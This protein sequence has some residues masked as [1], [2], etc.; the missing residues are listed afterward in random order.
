MTLACESVTNARG[1]SLCMRVRHGCCFP[2]AADMS[3][4]LLPLLT[5]PNVAVQL[6]VVAFVHCP[7]LSRKRALPSNNRL[8]TTQHSSQHIYHS[9]HHLDRLDQSPSPLRSTH[10]SSIAVQQPCTAG[11]PSYRVSHI[12]SC[13]KRVNCT[14]RQQTSRIQRRSLTS[15]RSS[16][17]DPVHILSLLSHS[18]TSGSARLHSHSF[19]SLLPSVPSPPS[20]LSPSPWAVAAAI[21]T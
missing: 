17:D 16:F 5:R 2:H 11:T 4:T 18:H 13:S 14:S 21:R 10:S 1:G 7:T 12:R 19:C 8:S 15:V 9:A 3:P 20:L 6:T